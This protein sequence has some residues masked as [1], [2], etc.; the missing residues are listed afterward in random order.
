MEKCPKRLNISQYNF[1]RTNPLEYGSMDPLFT[2]RA[3]ERT[4]GKQWLLQ[5]GHWEAFEVVSS[6][7]AERRWTPELWIGL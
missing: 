4:F 1:L 5:L 2:L 7:T 6:G 3:G